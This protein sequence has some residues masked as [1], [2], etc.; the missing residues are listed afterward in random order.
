MSSHGDEHSG[1]ENE[2][3]GLDD[4]V[5]YSDE[6]QN[7]MEGRGQTDEPTLPGDEDLGVEG[8]DM[9]EQAARY[10]ELDPNLVDLSWLP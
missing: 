2:F 4:S 7:F 8:R 10:K 1:G 6:E 9:G 5:H 3:A